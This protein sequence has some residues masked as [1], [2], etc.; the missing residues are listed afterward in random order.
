MIPI[1]HSQA[2]CKCKWRHL[3]TISTKFPNLDQIWESRPNLRI[4]TKFQNLNQ[5]LESRPNFRILTKFRNLDQI[6]VPTSPVTPIHQHSAGGDVIWT[7][8]DI[9]GLHFRHKGLKR[10]I[11]SS[12]LAP[13]LAK[14]YF[15][16]KIGMWGI[17]SVAMER[18]AHTALLQPIWNHPAWGNGLKRKHLNGPKFTFF[19]VFS[20]WVVLN[21]L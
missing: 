20:S 4:S 5:I 14:F 10:A 2:I 3:V 16:R 17:Q 9:L 7:H 6:G 12:F 1:G 13:F 19:T 21:G 15:G 8:L 18:P 11:S